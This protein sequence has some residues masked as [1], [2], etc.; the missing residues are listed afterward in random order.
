MEGIEQGILKTKRRMDMK[1]SNMKKVIAVAM[2]AVMT[3]G[4][5]SMAPPV[6]IRAEGPAISAQ[7]ALDKKGAKLTWNKLEDAA[8]TGY[9]VYRTEIVTD[10]DGNEI[11]TPQAIATLDNEGNSA[12]TWK[13]DFGA[14]A[15]VTE[16]GAA[17][18]SG[19][20]PIQA[21]M[22]VDCILRTARRGLTSQ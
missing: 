1:F 10:G 15:E 4:S 19:N 3:V 6:E 20:L 13:F 2:A 18:A 16:E 14:N 12:K 9:R 8:V 5:V 11:A 22:A 21:E 7:V 17:Q